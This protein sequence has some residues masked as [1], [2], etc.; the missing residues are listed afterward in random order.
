MDGQSFQ[1]FTKSEVAI[2]RRSK[3]SHSDVFSKNHR[4]IPIQESLLNKVADILTEN[5]FPNRLLSV[6]VYSCE[7]FQIFQNMF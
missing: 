2:H 3:N 7:F 5:L 4:K 6:Q 1:V